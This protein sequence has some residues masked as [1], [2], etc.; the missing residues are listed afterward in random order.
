MTLGNLGNLYRDIRRP[1]RP[2]AEEQALEAKIEQLKDAETAANDRLAKAT[3]KA[4]KL[5][6]A[7]EDARRSASLAERLLERSRSV[8]CQKHLGI[9]STIRR[10][11]DLLAKWLQSP[12][13]SDKHHKPDRIVLYIDDLDRCPGGEGGRRSQ[14]SAPAAGVS[15]LCRSGRCRPSSGVRARPAGASPLSPHYIHAAIPGLPGIDRGL[16]HPSSRATSSATSFTSPD[17]DLTATT[18]QDSASRQPHRV[19]YTIA[20]P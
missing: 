7:L 8:D 6:E 3:S 12:D 1:C 2:C 5:E 14:R 4:F 19:L 9:I 10:D 20:Y 11:F 15:H 17:R 13:D 18:H 16:R